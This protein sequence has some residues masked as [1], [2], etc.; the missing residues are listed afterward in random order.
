M[1]NQ[2][3]TTELIQLQ[4]IRDGIIILKDHSLRAV[5]EVGAINFE[6]RSG[7]E[8]EAI[9]QQF[10][11]FVNSIDFPIDIVVHSRKFDITAYLANVQTAADQLTNELLKS[12]AGEYMRFIKEL[13]DLSNIMSKKF[14]IALSFQVVTAPTARGGFLSGIMNVFKQSKGPA[15][16]SGP[17]PEQLASYKVQ[18]QQRADLVSGG[19]SGMGLKGHLMS[20][21]ELVQLFHD[22]Y[23]PVVPAK[24]TA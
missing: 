22:V 13:S 23:N 9:I 24:Q 21:E 18:L 1:A 2:A 6:L 19:L 17:T 11:G 5:V 10:Q 4:D 3:S 12:Q 8:Q 15:A 16:P 7:E 14:Y 20:Q